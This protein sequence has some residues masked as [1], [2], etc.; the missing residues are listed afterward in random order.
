MKHKNGFSL[1]E[2]LVVITVLATLTGILMPILGR[3]REAAR[4]VACL[5]NARQMGS[6]LL[7]TAA[8]NRGRLPAS[9]TYRNSTDDSDGCVHWSAVVTGRETTGAGDTIA[10]NIS[11]KS[12]VFKC[13]NF[14]P[15]NTKSGM[16]GGW[17]PA[18]PDKDYQA[19]A[20]AYTANAV[21][22]PRRAYASNEEHSRLVRLSSAEAP[23]LEILIAEYTDKE[24]R[25]MGSSASGGPGV[26][27][28]RPANG[29]GGAGI[30]WRGGEAAPGTGDFEMLKYDNM[31]AE[32]KNPS[33]TGDD[34]NYHLLYIGWDR[35]SG[36]SNYTF[37]DGHAA[38]HTLKETLDPKNYLWGKRVYAA[39]GQEIVEP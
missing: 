10:K 25:I 37:A 33:S 38:S 17:K 24:S 6:Y 32:A 1:V 23:E 8:E 14:T 11:F 22:M 7:I 35:H 27:S 3:T 13:P 29:L 34:L 28:H 18:H 31:V 36:R 5:N 30:A 4:A 2:I 15:D 39:G 20:M 16:S 19:G 26:K 9:Y 21:F 12:D